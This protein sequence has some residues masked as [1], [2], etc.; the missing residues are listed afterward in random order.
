MFIENRTTFEFR[1]REGERS[2]S[3]SL[4]QLKSLAVDALKHHAPTQL[5]FCILLTV[6][7][8]LLVY[9]SRGQ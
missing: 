2:R 5:F 3:P 4:R 8:S 9:S 6:S 7:F 1:R